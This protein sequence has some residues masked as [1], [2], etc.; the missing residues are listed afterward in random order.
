V[1]ASGQKIVLSPPL[2]LEEEQAD[3]IVGVLLG[4]L[5]KL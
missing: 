5:E 3:R 1:R 2:V 4:E